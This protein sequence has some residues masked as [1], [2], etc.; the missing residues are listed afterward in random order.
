MCLLAANCRVA[1][2]AVAVVEGQF[3]KEQRNQGKAEQAAHRAA[4][5]LNRGDTAKL[6]MK[7]CMKCEWSIHVHDF[8]NFKDK[9]LKILR[10]TTIK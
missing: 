7:S 9:D 10:K 3:A 1:P 4:N 5:T 2:S 6:G 8:N